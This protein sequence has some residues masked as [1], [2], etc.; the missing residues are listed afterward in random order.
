[1]SGFDRLIQEFLDG[2]ISEADRGALEDRIR[3]SEE[4]A[5]RFHEQARFDSMLSAAVRGSV[6]DSGVV[7][8]IR[9]RLDHRSDPLRARAVHRVGQVLARDR[10]R[11]RLALSAAAALIAI[12]IGLGVGVPRRETPRPVV[13]VPPAV[14][15]VPTS[16][17]PAPGPAPAPVPAPPPPPAPPS[18]PVPLPSPLPPPVPPAVPLPGP[19]APPVDAP[20][21]APPPT[22]AAIAGLRGD[23]LIVEGGVERRSEVL[24]PGQGVRVVS[25]NVRMSFPDGT[26]VDL[27]PGT[28]LEQVDGEPAKVV[29]LLQ[30]DVLAVVTRQPP[31]APMRIRTPQA[32]ASVLGTTLR[33]TAGAGHTQVLVSEGQV[34]VKGAVLSAGNLLEVGKEGVPRVRPLS[35]LPREGLELWLRAEAVAVKDGVV[36]WPDQSGRSRLLEQPDPSLR[37]AHVAGRKPAVSFDNDALIVPP[38]MEDLSRGLTVFLAIRPEATGAVAQVFDFRDRL[39]TAGVVD[40]GYDALGDKWVYD[41]HDA[42]GAIPHTLTVQGVVRMGALQ[43]LTIEQAGGDPGSASPAVLYVDGVHAGTG[44]ALVPPRGL[45][46]GSLLGRSPQ[47]TPFRGDLAEFIVYSRALTNPERA[48]VEEYLRQKHLRSGP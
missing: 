26:R 6:A 10:R 37:P 43:V 9:S 16:V 23:A 1:M 29:A 48:Q 8:D 31:T 39:G 11:R 2:T 47:G 42:A 40:L 22:R 24:L 28:V 36:A 34:R 25:G 35:R 27:G 46:D 12:G 19:P 33:A 21:P 45:R 30:G 20:P 41:V 44:R 17:P 3:S 13:V 18:T 15:P 14:P 7:Q 32:E 5:R 38:M 4:E